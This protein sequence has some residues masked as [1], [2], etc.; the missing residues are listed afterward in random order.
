[1]SVP[2][3]LVNAMKDQSSERWTTELGEAIR[4]AE[5][6]ALFRTVM[7]TYGS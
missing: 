4:V 7:I 5:G 1:M 6:A 2:C 3:Q